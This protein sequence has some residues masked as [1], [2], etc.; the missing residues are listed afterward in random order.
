M[1]KL[2]A[3]GVTCTWRRRVVPRRHHYHRQGLVWQARQVPRSYSNCIMTRHNDAI[4]Q[5][6]TVMHRFRTI[7]S[8]LKQRNIQRQQVTTGMPSR[9]RQRA[10]TTAPGEPMTHVQSESGEYYLPW[11]ETRLMHGLRFHDK[12]TFR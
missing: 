11:I 8:L 12:T 1:M 9:E 5:Y 7:E 2:M 4:S 10:S 6:E 3:D